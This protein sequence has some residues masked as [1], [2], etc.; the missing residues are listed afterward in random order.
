LRVVA[1]AAGISRRVLCDTRVIFITIIAI[2]IALAEKIG[3]PLISYT[4]HTFLLGF[5]TG[6]SFTTHHTPGPKLGR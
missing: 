4:H 5:P 3:T 6:W 1:L 2:Y